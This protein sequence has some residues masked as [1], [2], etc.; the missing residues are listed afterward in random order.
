MADMDYKQVNELD[1]LVTRLNTCER[2]VNS[3]EAKERKA[4]LK[5]VT[6]AKNKATKMREKMV[7]RFR[8]TLG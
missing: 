2:I 5:I 4:L 8:R 3:L 6:K 7:T 1:R